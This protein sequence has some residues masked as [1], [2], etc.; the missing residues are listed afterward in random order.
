M[1]ETNQS[2]SKAEYEAL[3]AGESPENDLQT[4]PEGSDDAAQP[5]K[6][7]DLNA[8]SEK[9]PMAQTATTARKRKAVKVVG[10][11]D[12]EKDDHRQ[13]TKPTKKA[14][15]KAKAIKLSFDD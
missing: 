14:K 9:K 2:L 15:K 7:A 1:E 4:A 13:E 12:D 3:L 8:K 10:N 11:N 5:G 6:E